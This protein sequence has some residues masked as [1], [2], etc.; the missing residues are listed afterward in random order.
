MSK[1]QDTPMAARINGGPEEGRGRGYRVDPEKA[2][3]MDI[4]K[5]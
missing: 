1:E 4:E 2:K 3:E 5:N